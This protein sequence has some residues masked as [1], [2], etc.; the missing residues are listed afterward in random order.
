MKGEGK[1][2]SFADL[3]R[4][5]QVGKTLTMTY[6][7]LESNKL[8]G[9]PRQIIGTQTNGIS[10]KTDNK[11][12]K[13]FL[14]LPCASLTEYDGKIIK[15]Y[16]IGKRDLT[17]EEKAILDN[18]PSNRKENEQ[19]AINDVLT[20]GSSTYYMDKRYY[21]EHNAEWRWNESRGLRLDLNDRRMYDKKIKGELDL[22]YT[23]S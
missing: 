2:K 4:D 18:E 7:N 8:V 5:L 19:L 22:Q 15:I 1:M 17:P 3:K 11:S 9:I 16:Q 12:G 20:D 10:L 23:L 6:S 14:S 21:A 13:S